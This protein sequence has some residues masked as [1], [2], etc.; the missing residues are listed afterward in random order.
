[1]NH[2]I[3]LHKLEHYGIRGQAKECVK[4]YLINRLQYVDIDEAKSNKLPITC[5]VPQGSILG[6]KRFLIYIN[7]IINTSDLF[8]FILFADVLFS[9]PIIILAILLK[10]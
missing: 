2:T 10:L 7:D 8:K 6:P 4:S 5:G 9:A 1:M 3:L